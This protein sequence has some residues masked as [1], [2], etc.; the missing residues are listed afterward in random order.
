MQTSLSQWDDSADWY[1][2]NMGNTGDTLNSTLIR[3]LM[4]EMLGD[5]NGKT[6]LDVGC[7]SGYLTAELAKNAKRVIGADFSANFISLC[8]QKYKDQNN[9]DFVEH[10]VTNPFQYDDSSFDT[11]TSKMVLQYVSDIH[12]FVHEAQRLLKDKGELIIVVDSPFR[13]AYFNSINKEGPEPN[14][15]SDEPKTKVG[16][17]GK[18]ELTWYARTTAQYIQ[19]FIDAGLKLTEIREPLDQI[20]SSNPIPFSILALKFIK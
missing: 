15:F 2:Q 17:W 19:T 12:T 7:G 4:L 13:A 11:I 6:L 14:F 8:N 3:P 20:D 10:D 18:T 9:L 16:L 5:L 1:D